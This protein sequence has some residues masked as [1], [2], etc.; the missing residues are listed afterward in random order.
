MTLETLSFILG[1]VLVLS[2]ILGGGFEAKELKI[3]K[4]SGWI[5]LVAVVAGLAFIGLGFKAPQLRQAADQV[6]KARTMSRFEVDVDRPGS[7]LIRGIELPAADPQLCLDMCRSNEK[8]E[9]WTYVKPNTIQGAAP[10]C[11]LKHS[12]P[13]PQAAACCVSGTKL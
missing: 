13:P 11:W 6:P 2:G 7:D 3:P 1:G 10:R 9:A 12:V 4:I 8:C 5:R